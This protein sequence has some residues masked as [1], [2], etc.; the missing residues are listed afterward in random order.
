MSRRKRIGLFVAF[1]EMV[2][3]R[4]IVEGIT[5]QCH[6]YDYDLCV[7]SSSTHLSF[8]HENYVRGES[9]IYEM[10]NFDELDGVILDYSTVTGDPHRGNKA[11]RKR[12][13]EA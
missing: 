11:D 8:P 3:V 9:N 12:Q 4:R 1:P 10:A 13:K 7:F 2:H 6:K 5:R